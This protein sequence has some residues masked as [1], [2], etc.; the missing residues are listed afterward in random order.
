MAR[1]RASALVFAGFVGLAGGLLLAACALVYLAL[2]GHPVDCSPL[3][4]EECVFAEQ[5]AAEL[6]RVQALS[7]GGLAALGG[8]LALWLR[9]KKKG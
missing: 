2:Y 3:S 6:A 1:D 9:T 7:A 4:S 8:G 5:V